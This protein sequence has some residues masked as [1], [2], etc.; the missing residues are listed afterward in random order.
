M[1]VQKLLEGTNALRGQK[2]LDCCDF[3]APGEREGNK[4]FEEW[5]VWGQ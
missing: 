1:G 4:K 3:T 5:E 2:G